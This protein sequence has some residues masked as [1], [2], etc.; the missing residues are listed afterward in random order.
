[1]KLK[2]LI[3]SA[4][5][6]MTA[7]LV[8][9]SGISRQT[10]TMV[11]A[12]IV[13]AA[14][15][16]ELIV[17]GKTAL[18]SHN[19]L[20]ARDFFKQASELDTSNQEAQFLY[21]TTRVLAVYE[22]TS[23][24]G[25]RSVK[26]I[27]ELS[28]VIFTQFGLY[29]TRG[30]S[31]D[32]LPQT[33]PTSGAIIDFLTNRLLPEVNA[34]IINLGAV[35]NTA[36]SSTIQPSGVT[37]VS[38]SAVNVDYA[39][40]QVLKAMLFA[41]QSKLELLRVYGLNANLPNILNDDVTNI[42]RVQYLLS[43]NSQFLVPTNSARLT[44]ARDAF[45]SFVDTFNSAVSA[46]KRRS[47]LTGHLFVLDQPLDATELKTTTE[48]V[49]RVQNALK[50]IKDSFTAPAAYTFTGDS[51]VVVDLSKFFNAAS[52]VNLRSMLADCNNSRVMPDRTVG[53]ILPFGYTK[54]D[55][56][57]NTYRNDLLNAFCSAPTCSYSISP[58]SRSVAS[59]SSTNTITV[60]PSSS[61]CAWTASSNTTWITVTSGSSGTGNGTVSYSVAANTSTSS[62]TGTITA[63]GQT[64]I[65]T[66]SGATTTC[67]YSIS[68]TTMAFSS[69][70]NIGTITVTPSS[71]SCT[72]TASSN[73][74]SW[75]AVT[76]GSSGTGN[77]TVS[78][79]VAA[80][81]STASRTGTI[82]VAN[83]TFTITQL[84]AGQTAARDKLLLSSSSAWT[85]PASSTVDVVGNGTVQTLKTPSGVSAT[86]QL[87]GADDRVEMCG[88]IAE[89]AIS[90]NGT[91]IVL[92][93]SGASVSIATNAVDNDKIAFADGSAVVKIA[94]SVGGITLGGVYVYSNPALNTGLNS[95]I[96]NAA[97]TSSIT[98]Q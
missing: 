78:Y 87:S 13:E 9:A 5:L 24:V 18:G 39:D 45:V 3:V 2:L 25:L 88:N 61:S 21:G 28:G 89:Y 73:A 56:S 27:G 79:S 49:D 54:L 72:W 7:Y 68:P 65:V 93:R 69:S 74:T 36:F 92:T 59:S 75:L 83:N 86:M 80:N 26:E 32:K 48:S 58:T 53:G 76:A 47:K 35:S 55:Q 8:W 62:R 64:H 22:S 57:V 33:T 84:G 34:A 30:Q 38:T 19:I 95:S 14:S 10:E 43:G 15:S 41:I 52:P 63:G 96:L 94:P 12:S 17:S 90:T 37:G 66:Q 50:E 51:T 1:M 81:S 29:K 97:D 31:P 16:A 23:T 46:V 71:S 6:V 20:A 40:V 85:L 70:S 4:A 77:G 91:S 98:C 82:T 67:S 11:T 44:F 60:S 42:K